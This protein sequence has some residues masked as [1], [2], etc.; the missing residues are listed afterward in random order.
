[1]NPTTITFELVDQ[2]TVEALAE[3]FGSEVEEGELLYFKNAVLARAEV[4]KNRDGVT[5][6]GIRELAQ[7]LPMM[8]ITDDH[9]EKSV[10]GFFTKAAHVAGALVTEGVI[11]ARRFPEIAK[12]IR[13]GSL[14]LSI[15][16]FA[17]KANIENGVRWLSGMRAIGGGV[18]PKPAGTGTSFDAEGFVMIAH[19]EETVMPKIEP[20]ATP[21]A[22]NRDEKIEAL[23]ASV[24]ELEAASAAKDKL[25]EELQAAVSA[26]TSEKAELET[27]IEA[28]ENAL[29]AAEVG[30]DRALTLLPNYGMDKVREVWKDLP[31]MPENVFQLMAS[32]RTAAPETETPSAPT[33]L[34]ASI[35]DEE[36]DPNDNVIE[37][38]FR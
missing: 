38:S 35:V 25:I 33:P 28:S 10:V 22:D 34:Q 13:D 2:S 11:Y 26:I 36:A 7:T 12:G 8:P 16:A 18:T 24:G 4:N 29:K 19:I 14:K 1:M 6:D 37:F 17:K 30:F 9:A 23:Q 21:V 15:E 31:A 20:E 27:K 32:V 5:L 3:L